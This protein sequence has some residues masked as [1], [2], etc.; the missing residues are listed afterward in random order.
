MLKKLLTV[1]VLDISHHML[2][3]VNRGEMG[4]C[5][6]GA[7]NSQSHG[8]AHFLP[9]ETIKVV[10]VSDS[11]VSAVLWILVFVTTSPNS[12]QA[13]CCNSGSKSRVTAL[14]HHTL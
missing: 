11:G 5:N 8:V 6:L 3:V 2:S 10:K 13:D 7:T 9:F 14:P 4:N 1:Y 12:E